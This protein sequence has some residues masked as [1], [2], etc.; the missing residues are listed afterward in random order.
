MPNPHPKCA[1]GCGK[2]HRPGNR[3]GTDGFGGNR[4]SGGNQCQSIALLIDDQS[5]IMAEWAA[6]MPWLATKGKTHPFYEGNA[7]Q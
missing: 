2:R 4:L 1:A 5:H 3:K 7:G 6:L